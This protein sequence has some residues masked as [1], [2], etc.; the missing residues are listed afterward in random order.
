MCR[1]LYVKSKNQF[2]IIHYLQYFAQIAKNSK[3][4]Q[5]HGWG[6]AYLCH[7]K[8][9]IYKNLKPI[10]EDNLSGFG[11][12]RLLL[13]HARSAFQNE[14]ISVDN[15][16]PFY[17]NNYVFIFNGELQGVRIKEK[18]RIGAEKI[19]NYIQRFNSQNILLSIEKGLE[20][21]EKRVRYIK[22]INFIIADKKDAYVVSY[23][24]EDND[25]FT[26]HYKQTQYHLVICSEKLDETDD[27]IAIE[28]KTIRKFE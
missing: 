8:W 24:N 19:F 22:A 21:L 17:D 9:R 1:L 25:Y 20:I 4:Y 28:N 14:D 16:M 3:E 27:W 5:G 10:W 18:G 6:L 12:T 15:N 7:E 11:T 13:A 2:E 26:M 23:F